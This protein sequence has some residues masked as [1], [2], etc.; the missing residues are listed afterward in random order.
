MRHYSR[1]KHTS[2]FWCILINR[3][4]DHH[5]FYPLTSFDFQIIP[6][7]PEPTKPT[8]QVT[9]LEKLFKDIA[10]EDMEVDWMELK[11]ILDH[12]MREG[13]CFVPQFCSVANA[14]INC[15]KNCSCSCGV[16]T[17]GVCCECFSSS[18][19][20]FFAKKINT[21]MNDIEARSQ[22]STMH[23]GTTWISLSVKLI[24]LQFFPPF[25]FVC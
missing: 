18:V 9:A 19:S 17:C 22:T 4:N 6:D 10:G 11:R 24:F 2:E 13:L 21:Q 12:S 7:I 3:A 23:T 14:F 16:Y 20:I 5:D 25:H 15:E 1:A 8:P